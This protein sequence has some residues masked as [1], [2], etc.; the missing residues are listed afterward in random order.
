MSIT[1][2]QAAALLASHGMSMTANTA[3]RNGEEVQGTSFLDE[4][5]DRPTYQKS[6]VL[7]W[8]GY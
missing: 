3:T 8:L 6:R 7:N 2:T 1:K 4:M 5:G